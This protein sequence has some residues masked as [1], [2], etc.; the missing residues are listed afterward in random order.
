[1]LPGGARSPLTI[2]GMFRL[3]WRAGSQKN[4]QV[5]NDDTSHRGPEASQNVHEGPQLRTERFSIVSP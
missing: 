3:M 4:F 1:M 2:G 5:A